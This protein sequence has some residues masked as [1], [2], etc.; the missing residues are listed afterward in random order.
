MLERIAT[1][2]ESRPHTVCLAS[3]VVSQRVLKKEAS[4]EGI[5]YAVLVFAIPL[6]MHVDGNTRRLI[7]MHVRYCSF[8]GVVHY[9]ATFAKS[10]R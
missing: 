1:G 6:Q 2:K 3:C 7:E 10:Y 5:P 9:N 4:G 8:D